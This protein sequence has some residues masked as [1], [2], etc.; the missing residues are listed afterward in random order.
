M[1]AETRRAERLAITQAAKFAAD[2]RAKIG[3]GL[4]AQNTLYA[5]W[6]RAALRHCVI[7]NPVQQPKPDCTV[8]LSGGWVYAIS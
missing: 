6:R 2:S 5:G 4:A 1:E 8:A 3:L 7:G